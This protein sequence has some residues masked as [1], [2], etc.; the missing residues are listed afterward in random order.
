MHY[1]KHGPCRY[2]RRKGGFSRYIT[3]QYS[4]GEI[5]LFNNFFISFPPRVPPIIYYA[6][7]VSWGVIVPLRFPV[8]R[9]YFTFHFPLFRR[10][11]FSMSRI[12][13]TCYN[14]VAP[15]SLPWNS[16][17]SPSNPA[18][19]PAARVGALWSIRHNLICP[20]FRSSPPTPKGPAAL[21]QF[22]PYPN[23]PLFEIARV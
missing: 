3:P 15:N 18:T 11:I 9:D 22:T 6:S 16:L 7:S 20:N 8:H 2:H 13:I 19:T 1:T 10:K 17:P 12:F 21:F 14:L 4:Q 23:N 5:P